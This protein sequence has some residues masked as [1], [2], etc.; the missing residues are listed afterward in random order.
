VIAF[1]I[2]KLEKVR[3]DIDPLLQLHW[4]E[5]AMDRDKIPLD[6]DWEA[7]EALER[8]GGLVILTVRV[9]EEL[10][11]YA[12]WY[13]RKHLHYKQTKWAYNDVIFLK[14]EHR[15]QGLGGH[16]IRVCEEVL[17]EMGVDKIQWHV[18]ATNDWT[19]VLEKMGYQMEDYVVGKYVGE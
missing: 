5:I 11:G 9:N 8:A 2:E 17:K 4:E 13:V 15:K 19:K 18:K 3:N 14:K 16:L 1:D 12:F 6:P 10:I 7:Y